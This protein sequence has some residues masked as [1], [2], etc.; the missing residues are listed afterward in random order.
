[1]FWCLFFSF[2]FLVIFLI[3]LSLF[4]KKQEPFDPLTDVKTNP[5]AVLSVIILNHGRPHNLHVSIPLLCQ[6]LCVHEILILHGKHD[7]FFEFVSSSPHVTVRNIRDYVNNET[8][9]GARRFF[10]FPH[11]T[12]DLI[13]FLDDDTVPSEKWL[14]KAIKY[15]SQNTTRVYV[16]YKY[17]CCGRDGYSTSSCQTDSIGLV[18]QSVVRK[19]VIKDYM[20]HAFHVFEPWFK[21]HKGNCEDISLNIFIKNFLK[22]S[23]QVIPDDGG[24]ELDKSHGY[25]SDP[26][27][28]TLRNTFCRQ[29]WDYS[30]DTPLPLSSLASIQKIYM[31]FLEKHLGRV[32]ATKS[33]LSPLEG[34]DQVYCICL[35]IRKKR[36]KNILSKYGWL[37]QTSFVTPFEHHDL[38]TAHYNAMSTTFADPSSSIY[39]KQTKLPVHLSYLLVMYHALQHNFSTVYILEDD[40]AFTTS[41]T[42]LQKA[43]SEFLQFS[44]VKSVFFTGY[45]G[46][47]NCQKAQ[48]VDDTSLLYHIGN[49]NIY[50]KHA[51]LHRTDYFRHFFQTLE[52]MFTGS[53]HMF[54][55]YFKKNTIHRYI[56]ATQLVAQIRDDHDLP[57]MNENYGQIMTQC[58][59]IS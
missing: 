28:Y 43:V 16:G 6:Y 42:T 40:I 14:W 13:L 59:L 7:T 46:L 9:G 53:D 22:R 56:P 12:K 23:I 10:A 39:F 26:H 8:Y 4:P 45:C 37:S 30:F 52:K 41:L 20:K 1:M 57:S 47:E 2:L 36:M 54:N 19:D 33:L 48:H 34:I 58:H 29:Y 25:H 27:H 11:C 55:H 24:L 51:I 49:M 50:C 31:S 32:H 5:A 35:E 17:R 44:P 38:D 15:L 18:G 21:K 3:C